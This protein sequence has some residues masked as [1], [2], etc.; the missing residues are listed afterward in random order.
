MKKIF[1]IIASIAI[2]VGCSNNQQPVEENEETDTELSF[3]EA[4]S[5]SMYNEPF[6]FYHNGHRYIGFKARSGKKGYM[7]IVHD[8]DCPCYASANTVND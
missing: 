3:G 4:F 6:E 5:N 1:L 2:L 8:P 7:G